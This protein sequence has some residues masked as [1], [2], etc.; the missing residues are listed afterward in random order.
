MRFKAVAVAVAVVPTFF[1]GSAGADVTTQSLMRRKLDASHAILEALA[2]EDIARIEREASLLKDI[3][4]A[5]SWYQ[6][7]SPDFLEAA[8]SFRNSV[9]FL[10]DR[11][12]AKNLEGVSLGYIRVVLSCVECHKSVRKPLPDK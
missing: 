8:K 9:D 11:A 3:S 12:K 5:T 7:T 10:A 1:E 2:L 4:S 6:Q